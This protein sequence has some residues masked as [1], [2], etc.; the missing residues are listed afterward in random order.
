VGIVILASVLEGVG[1]PASG[2]AIVLGIDRLLDMC[3]TSVNVT[4]DLAACLV[5]NEWIDFKRTS[6]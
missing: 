2:I 1:I 3:R 5:M 6:D 4:G